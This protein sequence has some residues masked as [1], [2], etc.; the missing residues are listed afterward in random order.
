M[1]IACRDCMNLERLQLLALIALLSLGALTSLGGGFATS[2]RG[3]ADDA[4]AET[5]TLAS[6][7]EAAFGSSLRRL[8]G[9]DAKSGLYVPEQAA[10]QFETVRYAFGDNKNPVQFSMELEGS[11]PRGVVNYYRPEDVTEEDWLAMTPAARVRFA[12]AKGDRRWYGWKRLSISPEWMRRELATEARGDVWEITTATYTET[13]D[14]TWRHV[15]LLESETGAGGFHYHT[16]FLP[17]PELATELST[18]L[19]HIDEVHSTAMYDWDPVARANRTAQ[20]NA[21]SDEKLRSS[22]LFS[23]VGHQ[24]LRPQLKANI[25][26]IE[27]AIARGRA[28]TQKLY[29]V[30]FRSGGTY[31][32][33][34]RVGYE[35]R[36]VGQD[37]VKNRAF[38]ERTV[39]FLENPRETDLRILGETDTFRIADLVGLDRLS[40]QTVRRIGEPATSG[41]L[42]RILNLANGS[43]DSRTKYH[44]VNWGYPML[45]WEERPHL[46]KLEAKIKQARERY[47]NEVGEIAAQFEQVG[48]EGRR[49]RDFADRLN[50]AVERFVHDSQIATVY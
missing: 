34:G 46:M 41:T 9:V 32:N 29:S 39:E 18:Y 4:V 45:R 35:F 12:D 24:Y 30:G 13:L 1:N 22:Y 23:N 27:E 48:T 7:S 14:E 16:T 36:A 42:E 50:Y 20:A 10:G 15:K 28:T 43:K 5:P 44:L 38:L 8:F 6:R 31:G 40:D 3:S 26:R 19:A 49:S 17:E 37:R 11:Q 25:D 21:T 47:V 2:I 33:T